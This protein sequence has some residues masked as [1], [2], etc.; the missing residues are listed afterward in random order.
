M[1]KF[2]KIKRQFGIWSILFLFTAVSKIAAA[3]PVIEN[4]SAGIFIVTSKQDSKMAAIISVAGVNKEEAGKYKGKVLFPDGKTHELQ[5]TVFSDNKLFFHLSGVAIED[6]GAFLGEYVFSLLDG[7]GH[8]LHN[9]TDFFVLYKDDQ[10]EGM[11]IFEAG[12][13][14]PKDG[15]VLEGADIPFKW[16]AVKGASAY[17][18]RVCRGKSF[19]VK[20]SIVKEITKETSLVIPYEKLG[21]GVFCYRLDAVCEK[22]DD[23]DNVVRYTV[24]GDRLPFFEVK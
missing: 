6:S 24:D 16:N 5:R 3:A 8:V 18:L 21:K 23:I 2:L 20:S 11:G 14:S 17:H 13:V 10:Y 9:F 12:L 4:S 1:N 7:E 19:S 22:G 15:D